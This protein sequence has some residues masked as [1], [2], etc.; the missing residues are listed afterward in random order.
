MLRITNFLAAGVLAVAL[1]VLSSGCE[2]R[3]ESKTQATP[4]SSQ[5]DNSPQL[6]QADSFA[7]FWKIFQSSLATNDRGKAADLTEY[8]LLSAPMEE[9]GDFSTREGF[10]KSFETIFPKSAIQMIIN[11]PA[12]FV[13]T[14]EVDF[15]GMAGPVHTLLWSNGVSSEGQASISYYFARTKV[16]IRLVRVDFTG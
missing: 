5:V 10:I 4:P 14:A 13:E 2:R 6:T 16:G 7:S 1:I 8:S 15:P 9:M 3:I 12:A 11:T